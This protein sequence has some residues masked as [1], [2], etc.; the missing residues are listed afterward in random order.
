MN[1]YLS[2]IFVFYAEIL[3][4]LIYKVFVLSLCLCQC[5]GKCRNGITTSVWLKNHLNAIPC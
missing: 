1:Q 5:K 3:F 2:G 4:E